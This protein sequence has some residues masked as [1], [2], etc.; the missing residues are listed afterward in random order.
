MPKPLSFKQR[1]AAFIFFLIFMGLIVFVVYKVYMAT[2]I[3]YDLQDLEFP[4]GGNLEMSIE[5]LP[6]G[7]SH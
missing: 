4:G 2:F 1:L 7:E 3:T 6:S 5:E